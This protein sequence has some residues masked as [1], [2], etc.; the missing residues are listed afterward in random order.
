M[1]ALFKGELSYTDITR[2][3][4]FKEMMALRDARVERLLEEKK[5][6]EK[7]AKKNGGNKDVDINQLRQQIAAT[8]QIE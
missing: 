2:G 8:A 1:L 6:E 3:M 5:A 4:S 7:A